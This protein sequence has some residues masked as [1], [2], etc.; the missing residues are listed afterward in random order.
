MVTSYIIVISLV[1]LGVSAVKPNKYPKCCPFGIDMCKIASN[2]K[3]EQNIFPGLFVNES[4]LQ[5]STKQVGTVKTRKTF[6]NITIDQNESQGTNTRRKR[7]TGCNCCQT[8]FH[9][10][11]I[12]TVEY[13]GTT[14]DVVQY[15]DIGSYQ[16]ITE[17]GCV[18]TV[19]SPNYH[20]QTM[21]K[22]IWMLI[23]IDCDWLPKM[24]FVP[25]SVPSHCECRNN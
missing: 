2:T 3:Q 14:H 15:D 20:C 16:V 9:F 22:L 11:A 19:C 17:G 10:S 1:A 12:L 13:E 18:N 4:F 24:E 7:D 6:D 8:Q 23:K 21:Y 25:V 5:L